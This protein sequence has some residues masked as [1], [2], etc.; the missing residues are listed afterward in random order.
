M[1]KRESAPHRMAQD[2][3][4]RPLELKDFK[5]FRQFS[6]EE[7]SSIKQCVAE[8]CVKKGQKVFSTGDSGEEM[9][10][11][12][13]GGVRIMLPLQGGNYR[14]L[15]TETQGGFFGE[16]A[17]IDSDA[18]SAD[19]EAKWDTDLYVLSRRRFDERSRADAR[20][21]VLVFERLAKAIAL[22]LRDTNLQIARAQR[23]HHPMSL[24]AG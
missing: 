9:F 24:G 8:V 1:D 23:D 5:L 12:R 14:H 18:R 10:L 15:A 11:V 22:R 17:F 7:L 2:S 4:K 19:V 20:I 13:R 6:D 3:E 16:L 21:G